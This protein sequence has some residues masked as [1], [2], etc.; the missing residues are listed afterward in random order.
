MTPEQVAAGQRD[1]LVMRAN[2]RRIAEGLS[3]RRMGIATGVDFGTLARVL[4][5]KGTFGRENAR[6]IGLWLGD[7]VSEIIPASA[8]KAAEEIGRAIARSATAEIEAI[9]RAI[10][11]QQK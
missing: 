7:D 4:N 10:L 6:K 2:E 3:F 8:S 9:V 5:G 1:P 11:E